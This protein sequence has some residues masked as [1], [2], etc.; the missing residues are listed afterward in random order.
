MEVTKS[1]IVQELLDNNKITAAEAVILLKET[2]YVEGTTGWGKSVRPPNQESS[3]QLLYDIHNPV[4]I[5]Q[6]PIVTND[7]FCGNSCGDWCKCANREKP[8]QSGDLIFSD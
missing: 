6:D 1:D 7:N 2:I 4:V 8:N 3:K 5:N